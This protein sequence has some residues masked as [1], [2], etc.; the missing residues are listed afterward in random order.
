MGASSKCQTAL[1]SQDRR[2]AAVP[3]PARSRLSCATTVEVDLSGEYCWADSMSLDHVWSRAQADTNTTW[4]YSRFPLR[5]VQI[6]TGTSLPLSDLV[7]CNNTS[8]AVVTNKTTGILSFVY[9][10]LCRGAAKGAQT[11]HPENDDSYTKETEAAQATAKHSPSAV[12]EDSNHH[13]TFIARLHELSLL[14]LLR[15]ARGQGG[16][17]HTSKERAYMAAGLH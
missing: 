15:L 5:G 13:R 6:Q 9:R 17:F 12:G 8:A 14:S 11:Q 7:L 3:K 16:A 10:P 4:K 2:V 1:G